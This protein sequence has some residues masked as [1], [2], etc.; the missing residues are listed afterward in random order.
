MLTRLSMCE[1]RLTSNQRGEM[2]SLTSEKKI[3]DSLH[4]EQS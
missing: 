3:N 2:L 4:R 1:N